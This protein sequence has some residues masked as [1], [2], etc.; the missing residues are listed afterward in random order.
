MTAAKVIAGREE[1]NHYT[2]EKDRFT[3]HTQVA[4]YVYRGIGKN[5]V[6]WDGAVELPATGEALKHFF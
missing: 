1:K 3:V 4:F 6:E 2:R 5:D